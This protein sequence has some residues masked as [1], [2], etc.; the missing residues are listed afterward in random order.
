MKI[1]S[2]EKKK[3]TQEL[4]TALQQHKDADEQL[5][6]IIEV[7]KKAAKDLE[8]ARDD[9]KHLS[10]ELVK[11]RESLANKKALD[12]KLQEAS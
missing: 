4:N 12:E 2:S 3:L 9:N 10:K 8:E 1:L 11:V 7:Q 5:I 6:Q